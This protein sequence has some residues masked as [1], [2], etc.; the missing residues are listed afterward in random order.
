MKIV[1]FSR[2]AGIRL[3]VVAKY[4]VTFYMCVQPIG[5]LVTL[6]LRKMSFLRKDAT[7]ISNMHSELVLGS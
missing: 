3:I 5:K 6:E 1:Q 4:F 2:Q 7:K